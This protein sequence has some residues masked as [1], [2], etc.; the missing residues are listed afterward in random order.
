MVDQQSGTKQQ[1]SQRRESN[2]D[3]V[4][5]KSASRFICWFVASHAV[6]GFLRVD[7]SAFM[8][9]LLQEG[10]ETDPIFLSRFG[11]GLVFANDQLSFEKW[12]D[13]LEQFDE[14]PFCQKIKIVRHCFPY[15]RKQQHTRSCVAWCR[16]T[17]PVCVVT[18]VSAANA[19]IGDVDDALRVSQIVSHYQYQLTLERTPLTS[20]RGF[21]RS[22][23]SLHMELMRKILFLPLMRRFN[24]KCSLHDVPAYIAIGCNQR[25]DRW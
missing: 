24:T 11:G 6:F 16:Y 22:R 19:N 2:K 21:T 15:E 3:V 5:S 7:Q 10:R 9:Y 23:F 25:K 20:L 13:D 4:N 17:R 12:Q 1:K 18:T 8:Y 14:I